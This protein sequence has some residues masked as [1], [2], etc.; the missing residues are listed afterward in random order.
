MPISFEL[1]GD[2]VLWTQS[3][4]HP[5]VYLDTFA[6]RAIAESDELSNR[7]AQDLKAR[8]GTWLLGAISMGEFARFA[9][10]RYVEQA[11]RL[12][13]KVVPHIY[14]FLSEPGTA[15]LERGEAD[16]AVRLRPPVDRRSMEIFSG[17]W[18]QRQCLPETFRGMFQMVYENREKMSE[19][20][21]DVASKLVASLGQ[22][23]QMEPYRRKAKAARLGDGRTRQQI[24]SGELLRELVLDTNAAITANEVLDL[25]HAVDAVDYCDLVLLDKAWER[26]ANALHQRIAAAGIAMPVAHC[27]SMRN[28]GIEQFL[29]AIERWPESD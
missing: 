14:L 23:R 12:L 18:S 28:D 8:N 22:H 16:L 24:I 7:F 17:L 9:D 29:D 11:E 19:T 25:M 13:A 3:F 21:D 20:L 2:G 15:W 4:D 27:F 1:D 26:R 6:I 5:T 10:P